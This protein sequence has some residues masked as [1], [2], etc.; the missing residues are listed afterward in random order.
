VD[1]YLRNM[2]MRL[3]G[4]SSKSGSAIAL[5]MLER[6]DSRVGEDLEGFESA[7]VAAE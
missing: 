5:S 6:R 2:F 4:V 3:N 7:I 1:W